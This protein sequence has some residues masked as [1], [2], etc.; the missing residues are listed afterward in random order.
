MIALSRQLVG[1]GHRV[2]FIQVAEL[3]EVITDSGL[4]FRSLGSLP[5]FRRRHDKKIMNCNLL[6]EIVALRARVDRITY[7]MEF[8]LRE[9]P[10]VLV[11]AGVNVLLMDEIALAGPT[12]A[13]LLRL[14]YF[15]ISTSVP[16]N[17]GWSEPNRIANQATFF[18][19]IRN[20]ILEVSVLRMRGPVRRR[21][22]SL[23]KLLGLKSI[24]QIQHVHS[25]LAHIT[26]L[27]RCLDFLRSSLPKNFYYAGPFV[28]ESARAKVDF[29]WNRLDG[30][31][32]IY[33]SLGTS[34]KSDV[35]IFRIVAEACNEL[36]L[37]LVIS[38]GGRRDPVILG[39]LPGDPIIVRDLPQL[40]VLKRADIVMSHGGL[41]TALEALMEGR[42]MIL[43]PRA[44][45]Q[46]AVAARVKWYG[47]AVVLPAQKVS[48]IK[49]REALSEILNNPSYRENAAKLKTEIRSSNG[50][51]CAADVIE[52]ALAGMNRSGT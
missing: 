33:A 18:E 11:A 28:D 13:Q 8:F 36:D 7:D 12:L 44:F 9:A 22:D 37:Q 46:P 52:G 2:T 26:Q 47:A 39:L 20:A 30:R 42:P 3:E 10:S 25:E 34:R 45:D 23:R 51:E 17:F 48:S 16:H 41:N 1:R 50:L 43:M 4:E 40:E 5:P 27:P 31:K 15:I 24:L 49:I 29:P 14:P 6:R 38:L 19:R 21:L 35:G 32:M